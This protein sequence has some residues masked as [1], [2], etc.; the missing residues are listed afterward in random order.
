MPSFI[1]LIRFALLVGTSG[2]AARPPSQASSASRYPLAKHIIPLHPPWQQAVGNFL[3]DI[4]IGTQ[5]VSAIMDTGSSDFWFWQQDTRCLDT[6]T[7]EQVNQSE[8][9]YQGIPLTQSASMFQQIPNAH[10]NTSYLVGEQLG[11]PIGY[12]NIS[13]GGIEVPKQEIA[14]AD[15]VTTGLF[16]MGGNTSGIVGLAYPSLTEVFPGTDPSKDVSCGAYPGANNTGCNQG[17]YSPLLSTIF[18]DGLSPPVFS[19]A[20]SRSASTGGVMA[21]GG[22][23]K[24]HD[25]K[26]NV[27]RDSAEVTVPIAKRQNLEVYA[28]YIAN[29]TGF[30]YAGAPAQGTGKGQYIVDTGTV[31]NILEQETAERV[32]ALFDPPA[33]YNKT[34]NAYLVQCNATAPDLAVEMGGVIFKHNPKDLILDAGDDVNFCMAGV[35]PPVQGSSGETILGSVFLRSVLAVFDVGKT[36]MTFASRVHYQE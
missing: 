2:V 9:G 18:A 30:H 1:S 5:T 34:L 31:Q 21:V 14:L 7:L 32:L 12:A 29:V 33:W 10:W 11:G 15:Y 36:Q 28:W 3:A 19:F 27:T 6:A 26:V 25:P 20:L 35:R 16:P 8:C 4:T 17:H 22:V 23:P 24:I 13:F